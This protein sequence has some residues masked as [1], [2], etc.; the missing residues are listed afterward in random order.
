MVV[1][2]SNRKGHSSY[3]ALYGYAS[4][5]LLPELC[6]LRW[7]FKGMEKM[8]YITIIQF[9]GTCLYVLLVLL[10]IRNPSDVSRLPLMEFIAMFIVSVISFV[11]VLKKYRIQL[12]A[13]P[14]KR[15]LDY[16]RN[17]FSAF[18]N[19]LLPSTYGITTVF[20]VG[21]FVLPAQLALVQ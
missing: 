9:T 4:L 5:L 13:L 7:F 21:F 14:I 16:L 1:K 2:S 6:S 18:I 3:K 10:F 8:K 15:I 12:K 19:L 11:W 17:H 20:I